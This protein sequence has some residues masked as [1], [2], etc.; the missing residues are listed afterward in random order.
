MW[1]HFT[2]SS[3]NQDSHDRDIHSYECTKTQV[4]M[5][6]VKS[7]GA[8]EQDVHAAWVLMSPDFYL[9]PSIWQHCQAN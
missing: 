6:K 8:E 7:A 4:I 5:N 3:E 1:P 2:L 9:T